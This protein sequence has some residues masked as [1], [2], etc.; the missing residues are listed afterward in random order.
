MTYAECQT[1]LAITMLILALGFNGAAC[2]TSLVNHQDLAP[3]YAGSLYGIMNTFGSFPGFIIPMVIG[4]LTKDNVK[5]A[6]FHQFFISWHFLNN[7]I[8]SRNIKFLN[9]NKLSLITN[10]RY[11]ELWPKIGIKRVNFCHWYENSKKYLISFQ[12]GIDEWRI[13]F[14][15]SAF[16]FISATLLFWLFGSASIQPWNDIKNPSVE[17]PEEEKM[18]ND[19]KMMIE[20]EEENARL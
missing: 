8:F 20:E 5:N 1:T 19:E 18:K 7:F 11:N 10:A 3:N 9:S 17:T 4:W 15:I 2:Q 6:F 16:V 14:W 13:M 12:N